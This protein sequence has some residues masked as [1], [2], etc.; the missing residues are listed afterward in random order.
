MKNLIWLI[1]LINALNMFCL[2][3]K[4]II[5][6]QIKGY[7][8]SVKLRDISVVLCVIIFYYTEVHKEYTEVHRVI[9]FKS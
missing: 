1:N 3:T 8:F 9:F 4:I 6:M 5:L 7:V 2:F